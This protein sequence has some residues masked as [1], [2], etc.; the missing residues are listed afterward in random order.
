MS[1]GHPNVINNMPRES[2][3]GGYEMYDMQGG[4]HHVQPS[5]NNGMLYEEEH[6]RE[7]GFN[8][9]MY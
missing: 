8:E 4:H 3:A 7:M 5:N 2:H 1:R 9:R 6:A